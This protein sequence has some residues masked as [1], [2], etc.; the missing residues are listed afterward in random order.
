MKKPKKGVYYLSCGRWLD[1]NAFIK[2]FE[3]KVAKT[4][5]KY[6]LIE[7]NDKIA[8]AFS[9]GKDSLTLL[10]LL[11]RIYSSGGQEIIGLSIDEGIPGYRKKILKAAGKFLKQN[12]IKVKI[13]TFKKE[14]GFTLSSKTKKIK[15]LNLSNCYVCSILKRWLLNKKAKQLGFNVICTAHSLDDEAETILLNFLKGNPE[16]LAKLGPLTGVR[17]TKEFVQR[18]KPFYLCSTKEIVL[19]A[20]L[21]KIP[22]PPKETCICPLRGTTLRVE[23]REWL[24]QLEKKHTEVKNAIVNSS[25]K[26]NP[27]L[28]EKYKTLVFKKCKKCG[29]ASSQDLCKACSILKELK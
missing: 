15:K 28:K 11:N 27:L 29:F 4:I 25:L 1:K 9:G 10:Y 2:Y 6:K 13:F 18:V 5:R 26:I 20:K 16:L 3:K 7:K 17:R 19:Y 14:F 23:I 24:I 21:K 22:I 8:V 12:N